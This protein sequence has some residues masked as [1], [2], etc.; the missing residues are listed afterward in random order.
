MQHNGGN[1]PFTGCVTLPQDTGFPILTKTAFKIAMGNK[2]GSG[3]MGAHKWRFLPKVRHIRRDNGI[4]ACSTKPGIPRP[5]VN[6]TIA[7][8]KRATIECFACQSD[9]FR[10]QAFFLGCDVSWGE[11]HNF[12]KLFFLFLLFFRRLNIISQNLFCQKNMCLVISIFQERR[13]Y[14]NNTQKR[15]VSL[16]KIHHYSKRGEHPS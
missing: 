5:S 16:K 13:N 1:L 4:Q 15:I 12:Y 14:E 3:P 8:A 6:L 7:R 10:K 9:L 2:D 11:F